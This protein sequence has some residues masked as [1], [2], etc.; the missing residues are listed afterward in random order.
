MNDDLHD[1]QYFPVRFSREQVGLLLMALQ[2]AQG[3]IFVPSK[4][5]RRKMGKNTRKVMEA[6][7]AVASAE[8]SDLVYNILEQLPGHGSD[9][10]CKPVP[11]AQSDAGELDD[12]DE[13]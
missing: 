12:G 8:L 10:W 5:S 13:V 1:D 6:M 4:E 3:R 9:E 11:G 2:Y 7:H